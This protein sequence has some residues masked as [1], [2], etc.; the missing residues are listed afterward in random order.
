[1]KIINNDRKYLLLT[2]L[3][4]ATYMV[5]GEMSYTDCILRGIC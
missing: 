3:L 5:A 4:L 2:L 1:M